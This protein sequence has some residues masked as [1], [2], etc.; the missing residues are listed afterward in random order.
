[1]RVDKGILIYWQLELND[2]RGGVRRVELNA[3]LLEKA[4]TLP[5]L[6]Q[7]VQ[8]KDREIYQFGMHLIEG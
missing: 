5:R 6:L 8:V 3:M 7:G 1:M 4:L 2:R